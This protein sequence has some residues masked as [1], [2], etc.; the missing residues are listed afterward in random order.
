MVARTRPQPDGLMLRF[1]RNGEEPERLRADDGRDALL[2][3]LAM[4]IK[5]GRLLVGDKLSVAAADDDAD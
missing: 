1:D 5:H 4:L 2:F 3:A